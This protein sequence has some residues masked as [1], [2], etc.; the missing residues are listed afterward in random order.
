MS[1]MVGQIES[2]RRSIHRQA[3]QL[4]AALLRVYPTALGLFS[5]LVAPISLHFLHQYPTAAQGRALRLGDFRS[6]CQAHGYKRSDYLS[7]HYAHL[8]QPAPR[9]SAAAVAAYEDHIRGWAEVLLSQVTYRRRLIADLGRLFDQHPDAHIFASLPGAGPILEPALLVKFGDHRARFPS[10]AA[11]QALAGTCPVTLQSGQRHVVR[12]RHSCDHDFRRILQ[13]FAKDS[14]R[15]C[16]W[17]RAYFQHVRP[18]CDSDSHAYRCLANRWVAVIWKLWQSGQDYDE[19]VH[20]KNRAAR[21]A[22]R[23]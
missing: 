17:A 22:P 13:Q 9:A 12:F 8:T 21:L 23:P 19:S 18:R 6:F 3:A 5:D 10:P 4:R 14:T 7:V 2:L 20:L 1:V 11:V 15:R 16:G